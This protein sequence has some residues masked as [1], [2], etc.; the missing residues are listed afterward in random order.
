[1]G[2]SPRSGS[3][4]AKPWYM[5]TVG[6]ERSEE[7]TEGM[8]NNAGAA[9]A[10]KVRKV[11]SIFFRAIA[12]MRSAGKIILIPGSEYMVYFHVLETRATARSCLQN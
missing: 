6:D 3:Q 11:L 5:L 7:P 12:L 9:T 1:M 2:S 8:A 4:M 10:A